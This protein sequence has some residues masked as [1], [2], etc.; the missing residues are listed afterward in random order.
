MFCIMCGT[1][2]LHVSMSFAMW[3]TI[4]TCFASLRARLA[5][6]LNTGILSSINHSLLLKNEKFLKAAEATGYG[7]HT[8]WHNVAEKP[9]L[10]R[11][12]FT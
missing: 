3:C 11:A 7:V 10:S 6:S 9:E 12:T 1:V 5:P 8:V 2:M 4:F